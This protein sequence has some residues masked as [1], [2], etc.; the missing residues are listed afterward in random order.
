MS[1]LTYVVFSSCVVMSQAAQETLSIDSGGHLKPSAHKKTQEAIAHKKAKEKKQ[2]RHLAKVAMSVKG[3]AQLCKSLRKAM[4]ERRCWHKSVSLL[5]EHHSK[6]V[7]MTKWPM[8][9]CNLPSPSK[10]MGNAKSSCVVAFAASA[11]N[12]E[13][14]WA[15]LPAGGLVVVPLRRPHGSSFMRSEFNS[16]D[17]DP[18]NLIWQAMYQINSNLGYWADD[19][20]ENFKL[21]LPGLQFVTFLPGHALLQ[22]AAKD[23]IRHSNG[24]FWKLAAASGTDKIDSAHN[25]SLLYHR[26][27]DEPGHVLNEMGGMM[28]EIGLGCMLERGN[29]AI[30]GASAKIWPRLFPNVAV[31]F[32]EVDRVCM[33]HWEPHMKEAGV[34]KVHIGPQA[35][36]KIL[37]AVITDASFANKGSGGFA[38]VVDDGSHKPA[39]I[40]KSFRT[41]LPHLKSGGLYFVEDMMFSSWGDGYT[42]YQNPASPRMKISSKYDR[43]SATPV[44]LTAVLAAGVTGLADV[45]AW[46]DPELQRDDDEAA[47][48][49]EEVPTRAPDTSLFGPITDRVDVV[50][51]HVKALTALYVNPVMEHF[52]GTSVDIPET[53]PVKSFD[54]PDQWRNEIIAASGA[55]IDFIECSPGICV[56]RRV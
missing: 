41:L 7:V 55:L 9:D 50:K 2:E 25:Y 11:S 38:S 31:H 21:G 8:T 54:H 27:F 52:K 18:E 16:V 6:M 20:G 17:E 19:F 4:E 28:L 15:R 30:A 36:K 53:I 33:A 47:L 43:S 14:V 22:K 1:F 56:F 10:T 37:D 23:D 32:I 13:H 45:P 3:R 5:R 35:D 39:D 49:E 51:A 46:V 29:A 48:E 24:T 42:Y 34:A 26:H 44:A 12:A 40:E